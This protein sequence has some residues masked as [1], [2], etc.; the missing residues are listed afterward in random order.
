MRWGIEYR[1]DS[2]TYGLCLFT[3]KD[4]REANEYVDRMCVEYGYN[5]LANLK[6]L[7]N[8]CGVDELKRLFPGYPGEKSA[9]T[10]EAVTRRK[11]TYQ[12]V[13]SFRKRRLIEEE[14][15]N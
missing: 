2:G 8:G 7:P 6:P 5:W 13:L 3:A 9:S 12:E 15:E 14:A 1:L 11:P 10:P 4:L